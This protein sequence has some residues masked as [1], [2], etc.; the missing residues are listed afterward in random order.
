MPEED[1]IF[2]QINAMV[3]EA[4]EKV[5]SPF[6]GRQEEMEIAEREMGAC[7]SA[8]RL[9]HITGDTGIGK[10]RL[11]VERFKGRDDLVFL[12]GEC[13]SHGAP[14]HPFLDIIGRFTNT[15]TE[16]SIPSLDD[17]IVGELSDT[18][19]TV[20][21]MFKL[22]Q[23]EGS[24]KGSRDEAFQLMNKM[25]FDI[26]QKSPLVLFLDNIHWADGSSL[27]LLGHLAQALAR[28]RVLIVIA[29]RPVDDPDHPSIKVIENIKSHGVPATNLSLGPLDPLEVLDM[30]ENV[31][32]I[33]DLPTRFIKNLYRQTGGNPMF[34]ESVIHELL[35]GGKV[36]TGEAQ[37]YAN[38]D[39]SSLQ[40]PQTV[41][42]IYMNKL[43]K[44]DD[45]TKELLAVGSV[46]G[47]RF[48]V[49]VLQCASGLNPRSLGDGLR[50]LVEGNLIRQSSERGVYEF[51]HNDLR[52]MVYDANKDIR[53][54]L[55]GR[56][57]ECLEKSFKM[58]D[59]D[60]V[61]Q[62]ARHF[63]RAGIPE[64]SAFYNERAGDMAV[65]SYAPETAIT[66]YMKALAL[67]Q[68][69]PE[70]KE[71][72]I[73]LWLRMADIYENMGKVDKWSKCL[74]KALALA[75]ANDLKYLEGRSNLHLGNL[76]RHRSD[77]D[78]ATGY[79]NA[80]IG[81]LG[82]PKHVH[83]KADAL[84]GMGY[85]AWREGKIE[86]AVKLY[87]ECLKLAEEIKDISLMGIIYIEF[88]NV[89]SDTGQSEKAEE[90]YVKSIKILPKVHNLPQLARAYNNLGDVYLQRGD[91]AKAVE[92]F[93]KAGQIAERIGN[94][95]M[96][97]WSL[98]NAS[99]ALSKG[100]NPDKG[101]EYCHG[102]LKIL[103]EIG[104]KIG[105]ASVYR[106]YGIA[107]RF[108]QDWDRARDSF[109]RS[110]KMMEEINSPYNLAEVCYEYGMM[111]KDKGEEAEAARLLERCT[112]IA[113]SIGAKGLLNKL[114]GDAGHGGALS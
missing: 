15:C 28:N 51:V 63:A 50:V 62:L 59:R 54:E 96:M 61:Y 108:K 91:W 17:T 112:E 13:V 92:H 106:D 102:A 52:D 107:Y 75:R 41:H 77:W 8:L 57:A 18:C 38:L 37:W 73:R 5:A 4:E 78:G 55:H 67:V 105:V 86:E 68:K 12:R 111:Y 89:Y 6:V 40:L 19:A 2:D 9:L 83:F 88:G 58:G 26:S 103:D 71:K 48:G 42:D 101:L 114:V 33:K 53:R 44:L 98:F 7:R 99:E 113:S 104:D 21:R 46:V 30:V 69:L 34:V 11:V 16:R 25:F 3:A 23:G 100:G 87:Q 79:Y 24:V 29:Q 10:S 39:L 94:R 85:V 93:K 97:G 80:A 22:S 14:Y 109:E 1:S 35:E 90:N 27:N 65:A 47:P 45:G 72:E 31:M 64:R 32:G 56:V 76:A 74:Q 60:A 20:T 84:R 95:D 43:Q 82:D 66:Y 49:G 70:G 81:L 110:L 36:N